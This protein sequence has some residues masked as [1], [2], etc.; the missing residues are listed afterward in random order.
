MLS[1][2]QKIKQFSFFEENRTVIATINNLS[3]EEIIEISEK[4]REQTGFDLEIKG[5][6]SLF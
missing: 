5:Q 1:G 4:F 2:N 3:S 6:I